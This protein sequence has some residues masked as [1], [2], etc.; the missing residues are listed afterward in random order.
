M[1]PKTH[2]WEVQFFRKPE[3]NIWANNPPHF[4]QTHWLKYN[5]LEKRGEEGSNCVSLE[6]TQNYVI[7][8]MKIGRT[9]MGRGM[10]FSETKNSRNVDVKVSKIINN[11][12]KSI[13]T[14]KI[15]AKFAHL[16]NR[17]WSDS[18]LGLLPSQAYSLPPSSLPPPPGLSWPGTI[19]ILNTLW[20]KVEMSPDESC[21]QNCK[22]EKKVYYQI[23]KPLFTT[24]HIWDKFH[25]W[26]RIYSG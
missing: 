17:S 4:P 9:K 21:E 11:R 8:P 16:N 22:R 25:P 12:R 6:T 26:F 10:F 1:K 7:K 13:T 19:W 20:N 18:N 14:S 3:K 23:E 5:H 15:E 2:I 24:I